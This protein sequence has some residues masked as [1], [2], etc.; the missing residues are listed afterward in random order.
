MK[1]TLCCMHTPMFFLITSWSVLVSLPYTVI[2]PD[3][4]GNN[5]VKMELKEEEIERGS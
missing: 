5:P 4:V 1:S 2:V 3:D